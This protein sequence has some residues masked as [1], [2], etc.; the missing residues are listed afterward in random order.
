MNVDIFIRSY[1][2]DFQWLNYCLRSLRKYAK[3]FGKIHLCIPHGDLEMLTKGSEEVHLVN[4]WD[5]DYIG[6][7]NDKLHCDL[8]CPANYIMCLD[9]DCL[10]TREI[11]PDDLFDNGKPIWLFEPVPSYQTPWYP[12]VEEAIGWR[13]DYEFMRRHPFVFDRKCLREFRQFMFGLHGESLDSWLRKRPKARFSE[14]NS[15]GAWAYRERHDYYSWKL[16]IEVPTFIN[17]EWSWGGLK[18]EI[19][20]KMEDI[21]RDK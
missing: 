3:G 17:Q 7:Q 16:P 13:P 11:E 14:F 10:L 15:Y 9:S 8:Y 18:P 20:E 6:Q 2:G 4:R 19:V 1:H 12:I 5:D 21:L